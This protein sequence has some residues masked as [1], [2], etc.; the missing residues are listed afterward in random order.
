MKLVDM[1]S[2]YCSDITIISYTPVVEKDNLDKPDEV[3]NRE[4]VARDRS[5]LN[6]ADELPIP[7]I[8][9]W[10]PLLAENFEHRDFIHYKNDVNEFIADYFLPFI[11]DGVDG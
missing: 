5:V 10:N 2:T 3:R 7:F 8:D 1:V 9:I 11:N 6:I 4:L